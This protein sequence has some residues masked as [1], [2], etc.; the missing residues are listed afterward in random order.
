MHKFDQFFRKIIS[1]GIFLLII[2]FIE[3]DM[4]YSYTYTFKNIQ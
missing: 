3:K 1:N 4:I 2:Y